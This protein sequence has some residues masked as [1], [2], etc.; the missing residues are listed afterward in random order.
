MKKENEKNFAL[1]TTALVIVL[2]IAALIFLFFNFK[3]VLAFLGKIVHILEPI[4]V[5]SVMA[6]IIHPFYTMVYKFF[7]KQFNKNIKLEDLGKVPV[8]KDGLSKG[9]AVTA[10]VLVWFIIITGLIVLV[11]PELYDSLNKFITNANSYKSSLNYV[12]T[13]FPIESFKAQ[14]SSFLDTVYTSFDTVLEKYVLPNI[15]ELLPN[16]YKGVQNILSIVF[17]IFIGIVVMIYVLLKKDKI[18]PTLIRFI[19]AMFD[20]DVADHIM[21]EFRYAHQVFTNF[22]AGKVLDSLIILLISYVVLSICKV[23]YSLLLSVIIGV[24]NIVPFFGPI[25]GGGIGL[26]LVSLVT[27]N[28]IVATGQGNALPILYF[29][30]FVLILQQF[31]GNVLGPKILSDTTGVD[32]FYVLLAT[33][34]FGGLFGFVGMIVAVPLWAVLSRLMDEY[35]ISRLKKKDM[36]TDRDSYK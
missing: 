12:I 15:S 24:T 32:S 4:I 19:Y 16:L 3:S 22:F 17:N 33:I 14:L 29:A 35:L 31:D 23:R 36:P 21:T 13:N 28:E 6:Y 9:L 20:K 30:I 27:F 26:I 34:L 18:K 1:G 10:S 8:N 7:V 5:G 25:I 11:I 2:I